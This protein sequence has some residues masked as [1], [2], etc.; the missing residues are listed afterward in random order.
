MYSFT[1]SVSSLVA[2]EMGVDCGGGMFL[3][4]VSFEVDVVVVGGGGVF[5]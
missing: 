1:F 4:F 3:W 2:L 5:L